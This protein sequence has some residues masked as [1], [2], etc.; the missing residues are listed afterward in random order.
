MFKTNFTGK[1]KI[2]GVTKN[3][4]DTAPE[5]PPW[6]RAW[7]AGKPIGTPLWLKDDLVKTSTWT[8]SGKSRA[9]RKN[10]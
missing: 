2:S 5:C 3:L 9:A 7:V 8:Y 4:G 1:S 10:Q 6:L